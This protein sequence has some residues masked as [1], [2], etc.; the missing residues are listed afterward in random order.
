MGPAVLV[1]MY[2]SG[3]VEVYFRAVGME[4]CESACSSVLDIAIEGH[5]DERSGDLPC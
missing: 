5:D 4:K 3:E 1:L 2:C